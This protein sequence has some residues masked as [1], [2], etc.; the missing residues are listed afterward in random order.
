MSSSGLHIH[1]HT[2]VDRHNTHVKKEWQKT[3]TIT[4]VLLQ[5]YY[6]GVEGVG[7]GG[8][9]QGQG[10]HELKARLSYIGKLR[11]STWY[12]RAPGSKNKNKTKSFVL[13]LLNIE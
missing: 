13:F 11:K 3:E 4:R 12:I 1:Q 5:S 6:S 7:H 9:G 8:G 10:N 2:Y